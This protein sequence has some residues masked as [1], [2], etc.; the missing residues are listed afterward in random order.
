[1][2]YIVNAQ[3]CHSSVWN[4]ASIRN[5]LFTAITRS[6]AWVRVLGIGPN[7][8]ELI[9][10]YTQLKSNNF[11]L[12]FRYPTKGEREQLRIVHRDMTIGGQERVK[13]REQGLAELIQDIE[14]G[15][16]HREDFDEELLSKLQGLIN[17][18]G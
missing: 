5:R 7:M 1:M 14:A 10:E 18:K 3:D 4:L 12:R 17:K 11:E 9:Q 16:V 8:K 6:K 2:V 15:I 13:K